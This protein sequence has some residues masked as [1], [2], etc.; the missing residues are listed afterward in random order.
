MEDIGIDGPI[1]STGDSSLVPGGEKDAGSVLS[2]AFENDESFPNDFRLIRDQENNI[3]DAR[4]MPGR[5]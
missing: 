1:V 3:W 2:H 5:S 4:S